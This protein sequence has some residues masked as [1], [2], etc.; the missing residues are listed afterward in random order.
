MKHKGIKSSTSLAGVVAQLLAKEEAADVGGKAA[1]ERATPPTSRFQSALAQRIA[2]ANVMWGASDVVDF[3]VR[4]IR[5][6][7]AAACF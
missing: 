5:A 3:K 2:A 6:A 4:G 7:A 1:D